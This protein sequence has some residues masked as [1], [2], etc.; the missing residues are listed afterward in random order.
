MGLWDYVILA[1][2]GAYCAWV[3]LRRKK[4]GCNGNCSGCTGCGT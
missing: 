1:A 2:L 3:L 4:P